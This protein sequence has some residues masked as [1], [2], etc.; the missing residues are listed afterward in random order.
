MKMGFANI[1]VWKISNGDFGEL[2]VMRECHEVD[3]NFSFVKEVWRL[4]EGKRCG[5]VEMEI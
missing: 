4:G 3:L 1:L 5:K 2:P